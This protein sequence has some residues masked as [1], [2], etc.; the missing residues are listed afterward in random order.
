MNSSMSQ[1]W[2]PALLQQDDQLVQ[3]GNMGQGSQT[4]W[5]GRIVGMQSIQDAGSH[6]MSAYQTTM[7]QVPSNVDCKSAAGCLMAGPEQLLGPCA[8][9][10]G[11]LPERQQQQQDGQPQGSDQYDAALAHHFACCS[12]DGERLALLHGC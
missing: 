8:G 10:F 4:V 3:C 1:R 7:Q 6:P 2:H 5:P 11:G 9:H 12:F